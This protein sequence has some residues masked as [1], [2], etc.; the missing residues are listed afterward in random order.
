MAKRITVVISQGQSNSPNKR[1]L[2]EDVIAQLLFEQGIDV[3]VIPHL[4]DLR[5]DG[6]GMLALKGIMGHMVVLSWLYDRAIRWTLDRFD[7]RG[8][9]GKTLVQ[10]EDESDDEEDDNDASPETVAKKRVIDDR[11]VP[12]RRIYCID[13]RARTTAQPFVEEVKRIARENAMQ[14]V[15]LGLGPAPSN[16]VKAPAPFVDAPAPAPT[17][18]VAKQGSS[19][20]TD[21]MW[22]R[23]EK[24]T[25]NTHL[26]LPASNGNVVAGSEIPLDWQKPAEL[27]RIEEE[28]GR[29]WYPV[30][31]YSRCTNCMECI[32]F[33]LFGV[34]GVDR[35]DTIL[36]EQPDNCRKGCPACS[37]VCPE[38]AIIFPQHKTPNIAGA[39][40]IVGSLKIDLSKLFGAPDTGETA[41]EVAI[42]ERDEQLAMAGRAVVGAAVGL[43]KR[44]TE[45]DNAAP[46]DE[47][48]SLLDALDSSDL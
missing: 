45:A 17:P 22:A 19:G 26:P 34:Y 48:D 13:L 20:T 2:E 9:E 25:N 18:V 47:L 31:D 7:I 33:C 23:F 8:L 37:R 36:V 40:V 5:P 46:K 15:S 38:N 10:S 21:E 6:T 42:R 11:P 41:E 35:V 39:P 24:P 3:V 30:I 16:V 29:R 44:Q 1:Q 4:Y 32:D 14:L 12:Q 28:G 27:L 43:P